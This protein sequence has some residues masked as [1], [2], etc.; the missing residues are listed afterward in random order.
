MKTRTL[1]TV[2]AATL[3]IAACEENKKPDDTKPAPKASASAE[4]GATKVDQAMLAVFA[5][6]PAANAEADKIALGKMLFFENR[7]SKAQDISCN[8]CHALDKAGADGKKLSEGHKK[9]AQA[10]NTPSVLNASAQF[11]Q[12]WDGRWKDVEE[13]STA[14]ITDPKVMAMAD[15]KAVVAVLASMPEY[16]DAF[17]KAFPADK[18]ITLA[19]AGKALGAYQRALLVPT[20]WD[21]YLA[22]D[23]T[24]MSDDEL[25][26]VKTFLDVGCQTCHQGADVG[27]SLMQKLGLVK[28]WPD[29]T[30]QGAFA[31]TK[32]ET[33]KMMF[34]VANL[35][36]V[37]KT[38]PYLHDGS[39]DSLDKVVAMMADH[40]LGKVLPDDQV[41]SIVVFLKTLT[42]D[43]P[44]DLVKAPT[45]PKSTPKTPKPDSK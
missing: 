15:E 4:K 14:H 45:L 27:G 10:R 34:K 24:A 22:G 31:V 40:Q 17:K 19:N 11:K 7:L 6:L 39:V 26:G 3:A 30:D 25:K 13:A 2:L 20:K 37:E 43:P 36:E 35:R 5:A 1:L 23:K 41:K 12:G 33:D 8:T 16:V 38:G 9:Q 18:D 21:K 42:A 29:Q 44:A 28:P 32:Q